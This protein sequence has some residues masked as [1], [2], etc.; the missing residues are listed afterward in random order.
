VVSTWEFGY[1]EGDPEW[2]RFY[3]AM[4]E[5]ADW[6]DLVMAEGHGDFP[7]YVLRNGPPAG[8]PLLNFPEISMSG[9]GPWGGFGANLQPARLQKVWN[10]CSPLLAGGFPY[11]EGIYEDLNKV[12][13][14]QLYWDPDRSVEDIVREYAAAEYTAEA[15]DE[16]CEAVYL[17]ES[18]MG[19]SIHGPERLREGL[20]SGDGVLYL[21]ENVRDPERAVQLLERAAGHMNVGA[22]R[23][24]RW[25][26]LWLRAALDLELTRSEGR[27]TSL[28]EAC[29]QELCGIA[30][31]E[32]AAW[33][34]CIP[35]RRTLERLLTSGN[36]EH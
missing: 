33:S 9:M 17:L 22:R 29:F 31:A 36:D 32:G 13:C 5:G 19:H 23:A 20:E 6:A 1:W 34:V 35:D 7:P 18:N 26:I 21:L 10:A 8:R 27:A 11:S 16:V 15:A 2:D 30:H 4:A 12:V 14:L 3:A 28:S 25:R 24:W